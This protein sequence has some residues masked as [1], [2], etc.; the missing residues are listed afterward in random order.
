MISEDLV[1]APECLSKLGMDGL[2][3][4][5]MALH[6]RRAECQTCVKPLAGRLASLT[7]DELARKRDHPAAAFDTYVVARLHHADCAPS[8]WNSGA[9]VVLQSHAATYSKTNYLVTG[10]SD[11]DIAMVVLNPGLDVV[12]V[13]QHEGRWGPLMPTRFL[14]AGMISNIGIDSSG[15]GDGWPPELTGITARILPGDAI[16]IVG[17]DEADAYPEEGGSHAPPGM[18]QAAREQGRIFFVLTHAINP[19]EIK[20][21]SDL[22]AV[23]DHPLSLVGSVRVT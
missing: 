13:G 8:R 11:P 20:S 1:V 10:S 18:V 4:I 6:P 17:P 12:F 2:A 5:T 19:V 21:I 9:V 16:Q 23:M 22:Q 3:R 14:K 7:F 15:E